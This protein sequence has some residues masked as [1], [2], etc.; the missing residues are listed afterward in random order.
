MDA[1][2]VHASGSSNLPVEALE[3][4]Y[5]FRIEQYALRRGSGGDGAFQGGCGV[6]RDYRVLGEDTVLSLSS[7]RQHV[8]ASGMAGGGDGGLGEFILN[9]GTFAE[10]R[11]PS[12]AAEIRLRKND[13]LRVCTPGGGGFGLK[14]DVV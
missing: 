8:P 12:A 4:A 5:P 2:R 10:R 11:L 13:L 7:E 1:V 6:I 9:P 14:A 3:H